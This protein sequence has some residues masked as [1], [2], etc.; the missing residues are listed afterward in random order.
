MKVETVANDRCAM[1]IPGL[2]EI[3]GGGLPAHSLYSV[4]GEPGSGKTTFAMQF[5]LEGIKNG[6]VGLYITFSETKR[7]LEKVAVSHHWDIAKLHVMDLSSLEE[8]INPNAQNT[9]FHPS[10]IELNQ[11]FALI[12]EKINQVRPQRIVFDSVSEMRLLAE[13][14]LRYRKQILSLKQELA[15][16]SITVLFL[17]DLTVPHHDLQIHSIAHGVI[18][19]SKTE[20]DF[21]GERRRLRVRKLRGVDFIG[22]YHDYMIATGGLEVYPRMIS[23]Q[24]PVVIDDRK[25]SSANREMDTMLGGGLDYGT[26]SL[27]IGPAGSGKSSIMMKYAMAAMENNEKVAF[28]CFDE[29]VENLQRRCRGLGVEIKDH[30]ESGLLRIQKINPAELSPGAF[31]HLVRNLIHKEKVKVVVIDSLNGYVLA[32][33]NEESLVLQLHELLA[34]LNSQGIMTLM[35]LAQHGMFG[36]MSSPMDLTYLADTVLLTRFFENK[37][38]VRKAISVIKKRTGAHETTIREFSFNSSGLNVGPELIEFEGIM[39]GIAKSRK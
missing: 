24:F 5:L 7:E 21:G 20:N 26:S 28:F 6:E 25:L 10:E 9:L 29:T 35:T 27:F 18:N 16:R 15:S 39:T 36:S 1:G 23:S 33:P 34:Y 31:A 11:V 2:D 3:I 14:P 32:M 22:G 38:H 30:I 37:G 12:V 13:T 8:Q 19:L 4:E 17:D